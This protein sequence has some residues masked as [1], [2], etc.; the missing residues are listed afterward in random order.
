MGIRDFKF[1]FPKEQPAGAQ[2]P[3]AIT[4]A[5][6]SSLDIHPAPP[7]PVGSSFQTVGQRRP[8]HEFKSFRLKGEY[9]LFLVLCILAIL[10]WGSYVQP[11]VGDKRLKRTKY[12]NFIIYGFVFI[13]I[14]ICGYITYDG[15]KSAK[16]GDVSFEFN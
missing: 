16:V 5:R 11:W 15:A 8:R 3:E 14:A 12:N 13:A 10:T 6:R 7:S 9:V 1:K 4:T 2:Q